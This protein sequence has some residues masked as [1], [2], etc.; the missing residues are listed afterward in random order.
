M[1][2]IYLAEREKPPT[3]YRERVLAEGRRVEMVIRLNCKACSGLG[4]LPCS[5][6][7]LFG[8]PPAEFLRASRI[9]G[10]M[11]DDL[12]REISISKINGRVYLSIDVDAELTIRLSEKKLKLIESVIQSDCDLTLQI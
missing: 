6:S 3:H 9:S 12:K 11:N 2:V 8:Y 4:A 7:Y 10:E 5:T 1:G